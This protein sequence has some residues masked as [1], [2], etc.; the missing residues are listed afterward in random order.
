MIKITLIS[1][2]I[3]FAAIVSSF[4]QTDT[5]SFQGFE[6]PFELSIADCKGSACRVEFVSN[7]FANEAKSTSRIYRETTKRITGTGSLGLV[8]VEGFNPTVEIKLPQAAELKTKNIQVKFDAKSLKNGGVAGTRYSILKYSFSENN[9]NT[10]SEEQL[11]GL[12][13]NEDSPTNAYAFNISVASVEL[14]QFIIKL[15]AVR[16]KDSSGSTAKVIIDNVTILADEVPMFT[17]GTSAHKQLYILYQT[18]DIVRLSNATSGVIMNNVG[19]EVMRFT[20]QE[21]IPLQSIPSGLYII[22]STDNKL[23]KKIYIQ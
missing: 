13:F 1:T 19:E 23:C 3:F 6:E 22:K 12:F 17:D 2:T 16:S 8:P 7:Y 18:D 10:F 11:I 14:D 9:G 20:D 4:A 5:L 21:M 15:T